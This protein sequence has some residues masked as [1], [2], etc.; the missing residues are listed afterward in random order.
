MVVKIPANML[1]PEP[2]SPAIKTS[3]SQAGVVLPRRGHLA[4]SDDVFGRHIK[5]QGSSGH[6]A[7]RG[8]G[9]G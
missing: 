4:T 9:C 6:E 5:G 2:S 7:G 8:R 3:D 1:R